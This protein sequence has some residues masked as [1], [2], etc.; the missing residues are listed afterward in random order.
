MIFAT[1]DSLF[2]TGQEGLPEGSKGRST[3]SGREKPRGS[4]GRSLSPLGALCHLAG[5]RAPDWWRSFGNRS[6][7]G[8][9][10]EVALTPDVGNVRMAVHLVKRRKGFVFAFLDLFSRPDATWIFKAPR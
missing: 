4:L 3:G 6:L 10:L 7:L 1:L 9:R 5:K 8:P 2:A